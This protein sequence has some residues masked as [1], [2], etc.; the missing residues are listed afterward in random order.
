MK[1]PMSSAPLHH[2]PLLHVADD[3]RRTGPAEKMKRWR[4][5]TKRRSP[6]RSRRPMR[7]PLAGLR[8]RAACYGCRMG[9]QPQEPAALSRPADEGRSS[10]AGDRGK[11][12]GQCAAGLRRSI[13][14]E[15]QAVSRHRHGRRRSGR[16]ARRCRQAARRFFDNYGIANSFEI[17]PGT[18]TSAVADRFQNH[19]MPFFSK[20][21]CFQANCS[22]RIEQ[23]YRHDG[24]F[25]P[26]LPQD[27]CRCRRPLLRRPLGSR[28]CLVCR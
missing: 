7:Q 12:H 9:A 10:G 25:A 22:S 13:H 3:R 2:E 17:Y 18:H 4:S 15:S 16:L 19:V 6:G 14:R 26:Q 21:L 8:L 20:N 27:F 28:S 5:P 11:I 1:H 24:P 23:E